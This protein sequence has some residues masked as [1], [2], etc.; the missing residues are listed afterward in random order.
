MLARRLP[1]IAL[2]L[3]TAACTA[4]GRGSA[5][6]TTAVRAGADTSRVTTHGEE[7]ALTQD[8]KDSER[9]MVSS[10]DSI[11]LFMGDSVAGLMKQAHTTWVQYRKLECDAIRLAFAHGSMAPVA[12]ME[13]WIDLT[14][15]HRKF[16]DG[17][18]NYMR[19]GQPVRHPPPR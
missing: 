12:Q 14:D 1:K 11:Y 9:D 13:C 10:E 16:L 6:D 19:Y 2:A 3:V 8:V 5:N 7:V 18:Y 17:E 4:P 15:D